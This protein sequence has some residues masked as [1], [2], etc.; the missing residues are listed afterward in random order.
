M[1]LASGVALATITCGGGT[2][3]G[4]NTNDTIRGTPD[5]DSINGM[6][7]DDTIYGGGGKDVIYGDQ[8]L[9]L[10]AGEPGSDTIYGGP[11]ADSL[12][13]DYRTDTLK[14]GRGNDRIHAE[15]EGA[16]EMDYVDCGP[17]PEDVAFFDRGTDKVSS[18]C[19]VRNPPVG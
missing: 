13:G 15:S 1:L 7:G 2:C 6:G 11:G 12:N 17:G 8:H 5:S 4:T 10:D 3:D 9:A 16:S 18:N 14:G 19:V